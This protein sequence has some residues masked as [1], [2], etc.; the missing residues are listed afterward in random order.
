MMKVQTEEFLMRNIGAKLMFSA[1]ALPA[2][3][4]MAQPLV[5]PATLTGVQ[6]IYPTRFDS[7]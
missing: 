7:L 2:M 3:S 5:L 1:L 6:N 4:L